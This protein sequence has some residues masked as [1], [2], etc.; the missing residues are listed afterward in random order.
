MLKKDKQPGSQRKSASPGT[1][2]ALKNGD[3]RAWRGVV[4]AHAAGILSIS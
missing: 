4:F 3:G 2:S 1:G